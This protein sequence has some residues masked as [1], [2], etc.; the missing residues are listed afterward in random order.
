MDDVTSWVNAW[1]AGELSGRARVL[2]AL[3]PVLLGLAYFVIGYAAYLIRCALR[4]VPT[5][6][7]GDVR[8]QTALVGRHLRCF[9][10]WVVNPLWQ[11]LLRSGL[12]PNAVTGIAALL[13]VGAAAAVTFGRLSLGGWLFIISGIFDAMD[14][15][16][17]R[18][19]NLVTPAGEAIDSVLDRYIDGLMLAGLA[20]HYRATWVLVPV[21]VALVGTS[22]VPYVRAKS[23]ALGFPVR[24]GLMQRPERILYL[25]GAVALSPILEVLA[26]PDARPPMHWLAVAGIVF[27]AITSNATAASR[28][29]ALV[30]AM[31]AAGGNR[32]VVPGPERDGSRAA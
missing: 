14:G 29:V 15:R 24:D 17:A 7:L 27:L 19:K 21:L 20:L 2:T 26:F 4:G 32:R 30:K 3:L 11:L 18:T 13:G 6:L 10:L 23:E 16:L 28:F 22:L 5:E 9:F 25:G 31:N 8:G 12:S 1:T